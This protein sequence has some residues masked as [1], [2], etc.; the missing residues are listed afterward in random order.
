MNDVIRVLLV[1]VVILVSSLQSAHASEPIYVLIAATPEALLEGANPVSIGNRFEDRVNEAI[2]SSGLL[3]KNVIVH[4]YPIPTTYLVDSIPST[5]FPAA[6]TF[7]VSGVDTNLV[8]ARN[9]AVPFLTSGY[10]VILLITSF[11]TD[12][13]CGLATRPTD[14]GDTGNHIDR[15]FITI[16]NSSTCISTLAD[17]V[18]PHEFGHIL[19]AEHQTSQY[20]GLNPDLQPSQPVAF[21]HPVYHP[22][23]WTTMAVPAAGTFD[24]DKFFQQYSKATGH[25]LGTTGVTAGDTN[26]QVTS[27]IS[28]TTWNMVAD[29]RPLPPPPS[30]P[31]DDCHIWFEFNSCNG[32]SA[33]NSLSASAPVGWEI[34][35]VDY[36]VSYNS[37]DWINIF[38]NVLNNTCPSFTSTVGMW[39]RATFTLSFGSTIQISN[40]TIHI[41]ATDCDD[42][43]HPF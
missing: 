35:N 21:N 17:Q 15:A 36:D 9:T 30:I 13:D 5:G 19:G 14:F 22:N 33:S 34:V 11:W 1:S 41:P 6:M 43:P 28:Q 23:A 3:G 24:P 25:T 40:C 32:N 27:L 42:D 18:F 29:Y 7:L 4:P 26:R 38:S 10:D 12:G 20:G 8:L 31:A 37:N 39:G 2:D 16:R